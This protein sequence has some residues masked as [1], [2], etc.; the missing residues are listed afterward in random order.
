[1]TAQKIYTTI[2]D[3]RDAEITPAFGDYED[4]FDT[5]AFVVELRELGHIRYVKTGNLTH[6]GL[7]LDIDDETFWEIAARHDKKA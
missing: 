1:M 7:I 5:D 3:L 4:D 6:D 2:D